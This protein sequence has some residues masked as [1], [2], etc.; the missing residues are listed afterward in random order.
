MSTLISAQD[1]VQ[2]RLIKSLTTRTI[3]D[4][5]AMRCVKTFYSVG[6]LSIQ[7]SL[8]NDITSAL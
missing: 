4:F 1:H 6:G 7:I 3:N 8:Y 5:G 2:Y